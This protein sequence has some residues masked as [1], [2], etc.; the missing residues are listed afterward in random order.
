[1]MAWQ[2]GCGQ[3]PP[4]LF[5]HEFLKPREEIKQNL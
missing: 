1:M 4:K 5:F 3:V 2:L